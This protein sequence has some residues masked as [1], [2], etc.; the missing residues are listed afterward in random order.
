MFERNRFDV[1]LANLGLRPPKARHRPPAVSGRLQWL[2]EREEPLPAVPATPSTAASITFADLANKL[3]NLI[4][5]ERNPKLAGKPLKARS[6]EATEWSKV[7]TSEVLPALRNTSA[8]DA[9]S[10]LI[11]DARQINQPQLTGPQLANDLNDIRIRLV[12]PLLALQLK[13]GKVNSRTI[14]VIDDEL[15]RKLPEDTRNRALLELADAYTFVG[16]ASPVSVILLEP[17]RFPEEYNFSDAVVSVTDFA[18]E[19]HMKWAL[20]EQS[21][22]LNRAL[23]ALGNRFRLDVK[24]PPPGVSEKMGQGKFFKEVTRTTPR[25]AVTLMASVVSIADL[26][27]FVNGQILAVHQGQIPKDIRKWTPQ[28][29]L[30]FGIALGRAMAHEVRHLYVRTPIHAKVGLGTALPQFFG[31]DAKFSDQD[32]QS[33]TKAIVT[34]EKQQGAWPVA[35][36][37]GKA[38]RSYDFPF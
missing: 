34:L 18:A 37:F 3:T 15:F 32:K 14:Y 28:Q 8:L 31:N 27:D 25:I 13:R 9:I 10:R 30:L 24:R 21:K 5:F 20:Y 23:D 19:V 17:A 36:S 22:Y 6:K 7:R 26:L 33:I 4:F 16:K 11:L 2:L 38:E 29:A 12:G 1:E 35:P